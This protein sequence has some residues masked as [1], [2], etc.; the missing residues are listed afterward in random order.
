[1]VT[2]KNKKIKKKKKKKKKIH[3]IHERG[4]FSKFAPICEKKKKKIQKWIFSMT[5]N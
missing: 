3:H 2:F 4:G 1:M 5:Q